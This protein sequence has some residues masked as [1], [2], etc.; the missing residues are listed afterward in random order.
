MID[1]VLHCGCSGCTLIHAEHQ[2]TLIHPWA[3]GKPPQWSPNKSQAMAQG[4]EQ[5]PSRDSDE[6]FGMAKFCPCGRCSLILSEECLGIVLPS[7]LDLSQLICFAT[8]TAVAKVPQH[9]GNVM[10]VLY[11][12]CVC[13]VLCLFHVFAFACVAFVYVCVCVCFEFVSFAFWLTFVG[14]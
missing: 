11:V 7:F 10:I 6:F 8:F 4:S 9:L 5:V 14:I 12:L 3:C 13:C 2:C 1:H